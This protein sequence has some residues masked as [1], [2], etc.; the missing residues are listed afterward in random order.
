MTRVYCDICGKEIKQGENINNPVMYKKSDEAL[1]AI[2]PSQFKEEQVDCCDSCYM[3]YQLA[4]R[5]FSH[6]WCQT[7]LNNR[8]IFG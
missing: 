7:K 6:D 1:T 8:I 5:Q 2:I 4:L 3:D